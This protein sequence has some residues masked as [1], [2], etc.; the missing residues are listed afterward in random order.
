MFWQNICTMWKREIKGYFYTPL[1]YVFVGVFSL[2]MGVMFSSFLNTY[3]EYTMRSQFGMSQTITIDRLSEAFY[4]NMHVIL[5]FVL[6]FFT[7]RLFTEE[8]RQNTLA[9]LMTSPIR[10]WE[11]T[12]AKFFAGAAMLAVLLAVTLIFPLFLVVYSAAGPNNGPDLGIIGATYLGLFFSGLTYIGIGLFWSSITESQLVAVVMSFATNFGF[13]L[14]SLWGQGGSGPLVDLLKHLA[15]NE[16]FM[17]FAKGT[18]ETQA[19]VYYFTLIFLALFLTN[20]S[21]ESRSWRA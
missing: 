16:Q 9:L 12:L 19:L 13:W 7:M 5:M 10:T 11:L 3:M 4:A 6:P 8:S 1:A 2:L 14:L 15:I 17:T 18:I 21:L 20:R